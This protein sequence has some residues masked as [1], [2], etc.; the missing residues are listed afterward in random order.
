LELRGCELDH[1]H[2]LAVVQHGGNRTDHP[3]DGRAGHLPLIFQINRHLID[4]KW[5]D[6]YEWK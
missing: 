1:A 6:F 5:C 4:D 3:V 2:R